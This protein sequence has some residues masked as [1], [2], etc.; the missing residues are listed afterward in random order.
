MKKQIIILIIFLFLFFVPNSVDGFQ[1]SK[2]RDVPIE[3]MPKKQKDLLTKYI[4]LKSKIYEN[5]KSK[6]IN[7]VV[8]KENATSLTKDFKEFLINS[9]EDISS[10][11]VKDWVGTVVVNSSSIELYVYVKTN[12]GTRMLTQ[13]LIHITIP[14]TGMNKNVLDIVKTLTTGDLVNFS[15]ESTK[16][17]Q[18]KF[19]ENGHLYAAVKASNL[20]SLVQVR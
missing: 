13:Q 1:S 9:N 16:E 8:K 14:T 7:A 15:I 6:T 11:G 5:S 19:N 10:N 2:Y 4:D 17:F 12:S 3:L 18:L 20:T